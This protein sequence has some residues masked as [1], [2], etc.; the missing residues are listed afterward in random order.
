MDTGYQHTEAAVLWEVG[1]RSGSRRRG[2]GGARLV[3]SDGGLWRVVVAGG[4]GWWRA[5]V[6]AGGSTAARARAAARRGGGGRAR[7]PAPPSRGC[8][9]ARTA[10]NHHA[11][12]LH[13]NSLINTAYISS[14]ASNPLTITLFRLNNSSFTVYSKAH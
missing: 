7:L 8:V 10:I 1:G 12:S 9:A 5:A 3:T 2:V 4:G 6:A 13:C 14:F 11:G